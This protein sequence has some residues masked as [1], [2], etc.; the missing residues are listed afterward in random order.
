MEDQ[1]EKEKM[2]TF[3]HGTDKGHAI[4]TVLILIIV[5]STI[6]ISL[7]PRIA[8]IKQ[9]SLAYKAEVLR[10]IEQSNREILNLYDF[11]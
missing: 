7:V 9:N 3:I 2:R 6:F 1:E 11:H 5:L 4:L 8:M 10:N